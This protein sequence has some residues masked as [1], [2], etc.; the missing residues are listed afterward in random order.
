MTFV[1]EQIEGV[2]KEICDH[3]PDCL[4]IRE[5]PDGKF[6]LRKGNLQT[7]GISTSWLNKDGCLP[8]NTRLRIGM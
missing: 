8:G 6:D 7:E 5:L 3:T 1:K 4:G 2:A